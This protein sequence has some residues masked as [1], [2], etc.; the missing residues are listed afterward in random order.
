MQTRNVLTATALAACVGVGMTAN[1]AITYVD[2][3]EGA[4]GNT[5]ITGQPL[6]DVSWFA[7][8]TASSNEL[9][10]KRT[11][12]IGTNGTIFQVVPV[13]TTA[14]PV[15]PTVPELNTRVTGLDTGIYNVWVFFQDQITNATQ[16]WVISAGLSSGALTTFSASDGPAVAGATASAVKA[17]GLTFVTNPVLTEAGVRDLYGVNL[18]QVLVDG[19]SPVLNVYVD[20]TIPGAGSSQRVHYDGIGYEFVE[21][22]E[23]GSL[24]LLGLG[25]LLLARRRRD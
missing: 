2:A 18:G 10:G 13:G 4:S 12:G 19:G 21:V 1:A 15:L 7:D 25:G 3:V 9:W 5:G 11:D 24:A 16:N 14:V 20:M 17:S 6:S 23:P 22:P 8:T